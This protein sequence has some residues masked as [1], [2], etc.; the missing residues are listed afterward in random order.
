MAGIDPP[1][2]KLD[3]SFQNWEEVLRSTPPDLVVKSFRETNK[4]DDFQDRLFQNDSFFTRAKALFPSIPWNLLQIEWQARSAAELYTDLENER[5]Q[6]RFFPEL[7]KNLQDFPPAEVWPRSSFNVDELPQKFYRRDRKARFFRVQRFLQEVIQQYEKWGEEMEFMIKWAREFQEKLPKTWEREFFGSLDLWGLV[8]P[9]T[10]LGQSRDKNK[11]KPIELEKDIL[12]TPFCEVL[13]SRQ[14]NFPQSPEGLKEWIQHGSARQ[15]RAA[16]RSPFLPEK[17][18]EILTKHWDFATRLSLAVNSNIARSVFNILAGD[19]QPSVRVVIRARQRREGSTIE[20]HL[21]EVLNPGEVL[22][23]LIAHPTKFFQFS[24][25]MG[26]RINPELAD[27]S[28][29]RRKK[30]TEEKNSKGEVFAWA[31]SEGVLREDKPYN[32]YGYTAS[33]LALDGFGHLP[34]LYLLP[35]GDDHCDWGYLP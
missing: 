32:M 34:C 19:I 15:R 24:V 6:G 18:Q 16:A 20:P 26:D 5:G 10:R 28:L 27:E 2:P 1:L 3:L 7:E 9:G 4:W 12:E 11:I 22:W 14:Q 13:R 33:H 25:A 23:L 29:K 8:K 35:C 31:Y 30:R 17:E 21:G